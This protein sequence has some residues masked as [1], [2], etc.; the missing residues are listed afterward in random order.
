M[1]E[2][3]NA[4]QIQ[5]VTPLIVVYMMGIG[6]FLAIFHTVIFSG[7][8]NLKFRGWLFFVLNPGLIGF[9]YLI[10]PQLSLF[11][12]FIEMI[13]IF[14]LGFV[15]MMYSSFK[16]RKQEN[17]E[18]DQLNLKFN[19]GKPKR[20]T[21]YFRGFAS[22]ILLIAFPIILVLL[23]GKFIYSRI[24]PTS[25]SRFLQ[26]QNA[27]PEFE[28][29]SKEV[30]IAKIVGKVKIIEPL[31]TPIAN[32]ECVG[33]FYLIEKIYSDSD[34]DQITTF[35]TDKKCNP[36]FVENEKGQILIKPVNL[37]FLWLDLDKQYRKDSKRYNQNVLK[38]GDLVTVIGKVKFENN[39]PVLEYDEMNKIFTITHSHSIKNYFK[40]RSFVDKWI[41]KVD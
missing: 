4:F 24:K 5:E 12:C 19:K 34:G 14:I 26:L 2:F 15:G 32:K 28:M 33:Y 23:I 21:S 35:F 18:L 1:N 37:D 30:G 29:S 25:I 27:L 9:A 40:N 36:F 13:S 31:I 7:L 38:N 41:D 10:E 20:W 22:I 8:Y 16:D 39:N 11:F 17:L 6:Y 3:I